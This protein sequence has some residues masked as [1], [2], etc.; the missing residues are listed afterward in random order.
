MAPSS[1]VWQGIYGYNENGKPISS[2]SQNET[3]IKFVP[4]APYDY[5]KLS[6][7]HSLD[8]YI[9]SLNQGQYIAD[10]LIKVENTKGPIYLFSGEEDKQWP[11]KR[12]G[13]MIIK[14]LKENNFAY[15]YKH[16]VYPNVN[17]GFSA[18]QTESQGGTRQANKAALEDFEKKVLLLLEKINSM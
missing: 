3:G 2:W 4:Y 10:A 15:E 18:E 12:M 5:S 17:H 6:N 13:E 1:V 7:G 14:R 8:F 9:K 16:Y 11:S